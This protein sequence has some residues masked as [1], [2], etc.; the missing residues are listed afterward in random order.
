MKKKAFHKKLSLNKKTVVN[1]DNNEMNTIKAGVD[2]LYICTGRNT[3]GA[4]PATIY[5]C[6]TELC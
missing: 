1:I 6:Q 2:T 4:C 3:C 5:N